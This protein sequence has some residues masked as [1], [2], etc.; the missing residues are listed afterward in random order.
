MIARINLMVRIDQAMD[1]CR[2]GWMPYPTL[3][4]THHGAWSVHVGWVCDCIP[5]L[6]VDDELAHLATAVA[7]LEASR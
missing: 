7:S 2:L 1:Y 5:R 6:P 3:E 4:G